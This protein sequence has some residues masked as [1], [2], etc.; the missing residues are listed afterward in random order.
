MENI[1]VDAAAAGQPTISPPPALGNDSNMRSVSG[2]PRFTSPPSIPLPGTAPATPLLPE[3]GQH[4]SE[5][6][7]ESATD[8]L[9]F[10]L[11]RLNRSGTSF[12]LARILSDRK[13]NGVA[14]ANAYTSGSSTSQQPA[15]NVDGNGHGG[16]HDEPSGPIGSATSQMDPEDWDDATNSATEVQSCLALIDDTDTTR[17]WHASISSFAA[18]NERSYFFAVLLVSPQSA[19]ERPP[20]MLPEHI[21]PTEP[22]TRPNLSRKKSEPVKGPATI[23]DCVDESTWDGR[24]VPDEFYK[25]R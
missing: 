24:K 12:T 7:R 16:N 20:V 6:F 2:T 4:S 5:I 21:S 1:S 19:P 17:W 8:K 9:G 13:G 10:H 11:A 23:E 3:Y 18:S 22:L 15:K 14:Y 25:V